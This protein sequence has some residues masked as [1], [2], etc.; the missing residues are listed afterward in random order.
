MGYRAGRL[1]EEIKK[2]L[3]DLLQTELKDPRINPMTSVTSVNVS[4]DLRYA[5]VYVSVL[6][7]E[8]KKKETLEGLKSASGFIRSELGKRIRL[9][10]HPEIS[11]EL[12]ESIQ[13]SLEINRILRDLKQDKGCD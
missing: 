2:V 11:F 8:D 4:K 9:R 10:Y 5:K 6:G 13:H 12:D 3:T 7:T 1:A